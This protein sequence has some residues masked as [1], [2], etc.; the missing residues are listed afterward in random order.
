MLKRTDVS[1]V[2]VMGVKAVFGLS[3]RFDR[4]KKPTSGAPRV[5]Q[6]RACP[7]EVLHVAGSHG[8]VA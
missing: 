6:A 2:L 1:T 3:S 8:A 5:D 4:E 7:F